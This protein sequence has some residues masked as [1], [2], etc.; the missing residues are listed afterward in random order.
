M[1]VGKLFEGGYQQTEFLP[2]SRHKRMEGGN[3][4]DAKPGSRF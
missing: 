4:Q 1:I 3:P 2:I